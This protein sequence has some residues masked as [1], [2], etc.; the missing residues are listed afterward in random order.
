MD[1]WVICERVAV[2]TMEFC[3]PTLQSEPF[4]KQ[5]TP[6]PDLREY[7]KHISA[8]D[9]PSAPLIPLGSHYVLQNELRERGKRMYKDTTGKQHTK[10]IL[11]SGTNLVM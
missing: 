8:A 7:S 5:D 2:W 11:Y 9:S 6:T 3:R 4:A 1:F 10:F